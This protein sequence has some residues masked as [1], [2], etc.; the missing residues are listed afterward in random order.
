VCCVAHPRSVC[1]SYA[2]LACVLL[3]T[4]RVAFVLDADSLG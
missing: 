1:A 3:R 2:V 4:F